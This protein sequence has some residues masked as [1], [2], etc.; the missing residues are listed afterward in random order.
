M[1][2]PGAAAHVPV[3]QQLR[4]GTLLIWVFLGNLVLRYHH[5]M[6]K[7]RDSKFIK[8]QPLRFSKEKNEVPKGKLLKVTDM[9]IFII[10][11]CM[12]IFLGPFEMALDTIDWETEHLSEVP[13]QP[14]S[15]Y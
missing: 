4:S 8:T 3:P 14:S 2:G 13:I 15:G 6:S 9:N 12:Q 1:T 7:S 10:Y 11:F 5:H